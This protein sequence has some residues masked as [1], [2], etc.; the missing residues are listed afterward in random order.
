VRERKPVPNAI[1]FAGLHVGRK[2]IALAG[3]SFDETRLGGIII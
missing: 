3:N 1:S 2:T